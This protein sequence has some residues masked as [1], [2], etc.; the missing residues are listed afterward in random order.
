MSSGTR[1]GVEDH[2]TRDRSNLEKKRRFWFIRNPEA[3]RH[4]DRCISVNLQPDKIR[5]SFITWILHF[6]DRLN[7]GTSAAQDWVSRRAIGPPA[8]KSIAVPRL[9]D[10][11]NGHSILVEPFGG[12]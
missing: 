4:F 1:L 3:D 12:I 2:E 9:T 8:K 6:C 7:Q 10:R 5:V 11:V